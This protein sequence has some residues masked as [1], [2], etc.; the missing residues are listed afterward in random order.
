MLGWPANGEADVLAL[1][2]FGDVLKGA[3]L[4]LEALAKPILASEVVNIVREHN[5]RAVCIADLPPSAPSKSR[6]LIKRLRSEA[7]DV[8]I[9]VGRWGAGGDELEA[10]ALLAAGADRVESRLLDTRDQLCRLLSVAAAEAS[11]S[12]IDQPPRQ[13]G[14]TA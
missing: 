10:A 11:A 12:V 7:P 1:R 8:K 3:P 13:I 4:R 2:M 6:Y 14:G 5:C 9:V